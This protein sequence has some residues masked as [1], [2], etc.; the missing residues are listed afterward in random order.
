MS[1]IFGWLRLRSGSVIAPS[2]AHGTL[3]G[4]AGL[5]LVVLRG[6]NDLTVGLTGLAGMIA[7]AAANLLLFIYLRRAP[8][9]K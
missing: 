3:N 1:P 5:A 4:T 8:L 7:L 2:I 9:R 6:G